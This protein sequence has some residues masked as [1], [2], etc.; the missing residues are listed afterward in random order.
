[1]QLFGVEHDNFIIP[2]R[3]VLFLVIDE[4]DEVI[5]KHVKIVPKGNYK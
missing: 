1:M 2:Q 4:K 3:P 5:S